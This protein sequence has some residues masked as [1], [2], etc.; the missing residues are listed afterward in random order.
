MLHEDQQCKQHV[1]LPE[2]ACKEHSRVTEL[3]DLIGLPRNEITRSRTY[4]GTDM[5][6][7]LMIA[8]QEQHGAD[9]ASDHS[10]VE[11]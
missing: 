1:E 2:F 6:S 3:I 11:G 7:I 9:I 10:V 8:Q 4:L 5:V